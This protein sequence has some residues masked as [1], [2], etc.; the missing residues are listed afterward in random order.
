M[1]NETKKNPVEISTFTHDRGVKAGGGRVPPSSRRR[2]D[3]VYIIRTI[4]SYTVD[5]FFF[6]YYIFLYSFFLLQYD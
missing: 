4:A 5:V 3:G 2:R 1:T 6:H